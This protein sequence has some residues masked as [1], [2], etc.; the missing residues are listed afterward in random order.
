MGAPPYAIGSYKRVKY[1]SESE[2]FD[3]QIFIDNNGTFVKFENEVDPTTARVSL[4]TKIV[5][6]MQEVGGRAVYVSHH[7][8]KWASFVWTHD[9][10]LLIDTVQKQPYAIHYHSSLARGQAL[11]CS[12]KCRLLMVKSKV[13]PFIVAITC[14]VICISEKWSIIC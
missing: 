14:Q 9:K 3:K 11:R 4:V 10:R 2:Q 13:L 7:K 8:P 6:T 5:S 1:L 12:G